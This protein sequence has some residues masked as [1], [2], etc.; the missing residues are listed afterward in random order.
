MAPNKTI[1]RTIDHI[2]CPAVNAVV[3]FDVK[4]KHMS[5]KTL[6]TISGSKATQQHMQYLLI[7]K[8]CDSY[9]CATIITTNASECCLL[10]SAQHSTQSP[11]AST[12]QSSTLYPEF[13][14]LGIG[15]TF[16]PLYCVLS[17]FL[18]ML[19]CF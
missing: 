4:P 8:Y 5:H 18:F 14:T 10:I 19:I 3:Y 13:H 1:N 9:T 6:P 12:L 16:P 2:A 15:L 7:S 11:H 17:P